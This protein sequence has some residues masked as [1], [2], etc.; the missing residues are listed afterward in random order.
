MIVECPQEENAVKIDGHYISLGR[1]TK[2][3]LLALITIG[4]PNAGDKHVVVCSVHVV[5]D[6]KEA[7]DWFAKSL[8]EKPWLPRS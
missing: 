2:G 8:T 5:K 7:T 3:R 1:D 4:H 6:R